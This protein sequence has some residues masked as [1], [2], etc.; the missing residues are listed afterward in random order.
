M[1]RLFIALILSFLFG[2]IFCQTQ[3]ELTNKAKTDYEKIDKELNVVYLKIFEKYSDDSIFIKQFKHSEI[4][5]IKYKDAQVKMKF[6]P[7][8]NSDGSSLTMCRY[9][10][11]IEIIRKRITELNQWLDG[12]EEGDV[13]S[14]SVKF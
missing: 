1:K 6:P 7:Y 13:C 8:P 5:W 4:Q 11:M 10:Y 3:I 14:G 12:T 9:N 2:E